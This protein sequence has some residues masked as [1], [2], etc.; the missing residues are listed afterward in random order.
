MFGKWSNR[1]REK[2]LAICQQC[3]VNVWSLMVTLLESIN[4]TC[5]TNALTADRIHS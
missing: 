3:M 4:K 5:T 2:T 1:L